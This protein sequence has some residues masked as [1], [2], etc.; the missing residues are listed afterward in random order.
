MTLAQAAVQGL[1]ALRARAAAPVA[2]SANLRV[3]RD[4]E[5]VQV[6]V[7]KHAKLGAQVLA[8]QEAGGYLPQVRG[9]AEHQ[10]YR[11]PIHAPAGAGRGMNSSAL[12]VRDDVPVHAQGVALSRASWIG[13]RAGIVWPGRGIPWAVAD[14]DGQ[15]TLVAS[16]HGPTGRNGD[17]K[18]A[19]R[20][21]MRRL[22]RLAKR[23][24]RKYRAKV[25]YVGD[26]N[27]PVGARDKRSV[28]RLLANRIGAHVVNPGARPPIDYAVTHLDLRGETG[29]RHGSD[30]DSIRFYWKDSR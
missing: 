10:G 21:Y 4:P 28:R 17:N 26:W 20:K 25:L 9:V 14:L 1:D 5:A 12:L 6:A 13:P 30:H 19:W 11:D 22:R 7:R 3:L 2:V 18:R 23:K 24:G 29:P 27:C 8:L 15:R 16:I